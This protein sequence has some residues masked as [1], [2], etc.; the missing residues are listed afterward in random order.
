MMARKL[1]L[2]NL[3]VV[4]F[5]LGAMIPTLLLSSLLIS[6][7]R[8]IQAD[9]QIKKQRAETDKAVLQL[10]FELEKF[11]LQLQQLSTDSNATLAASSG[12]FAQNARNRLLQIADQHPLAKAVLLIDKTS[13]IV[14][15]VPVEAMVLSLQ[16]LQSH[17]SELFAQDY[18]ATSTTY[19][20]SSDTLSQVLLAKAD[21]QAV[22]AAELIVMQM[23]LKLTDT[24]D[25]DPRSKLTGALIALLPVHSIKAMLEQYAPDAN[26]HNIY[27][28]QRGL[29][30]SSPPADDSVIT[31]SQLH[32]PGLV[33]PLTIEFTT[34][35]ADALRAITTLT[36]RFALITAVF[37]LVILLIGWVFVQRQV[38]PITALSRL[39]ERYTEGDL[40]QP[41]QHF[42][43][44]EFEQISAVLHTMGLKLKEHQDLLEG[45]VEQRTAQLQQAVT[46]LNQMNTELM[47]TQQQL[48]ESEKLSQ[49]GILVAGVAREIT[50]P[51]TKS[52][53][54]ITTIQHQQVQLDQAVKT[55][56]LKKSTF[57]AYLRESKHAVT[58][59]HQH[60]QR[61]EELIQS[62]KAVAVDQS[63]EQRRNFN[64]YDYLQQIILSLRYELGQ[65]DV[66]V[67]IKGD[68]MMVLQSYPGSF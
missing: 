40:H 66:K 7:F 11:A 46:E 51:I 55:S 62:F 23:P 57:D 15:A 10:S 53:D 64:L 37:L 22:V 47:K 67:E 32:V 45:R 4:Q 6:A 30:T 14:E 1:S 25:T 38:K 3:L 24:R 5:V 49:I 48:I 42:V 2:K 8:T 26:L 52:L 68:K 43:F 41:R 31:R 61:A 35:K 21:T 33:M 9:E 65:Q 34:T 16:P 63:S 56:T 54:A 59:L 44:T 13:W 58:L 28:Q 60:L 27:W 20:L 18:A 36:Y 50:A 39:V 19:V 12:I 29:L 17:L